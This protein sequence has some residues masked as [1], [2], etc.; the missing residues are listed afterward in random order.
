M[1]KIVYYMDTTQ[2][3][4]ILVIQK[5]HLEIRKILKF[6]TKNIGKAYV[7]DS[8]LSY[9]EKH[10]R[11]NVTCISDYKKESGN[12]CIFTGQAGSGKTTKLC[13]MVIATKK[14]FGVIIYK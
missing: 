2:M 7:T 14:S 1:V 5:C 9:F 10:Y 8:T 12:G 4:Y 11:E 3:E 13:K 6:N